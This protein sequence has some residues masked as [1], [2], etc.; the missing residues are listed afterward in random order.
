VYKKI[1][2]RELVVDGQTLLQALERRRF[3]V[4]G[5]FWIQ[6]EGESDDWTLVIASPVVDLVGP[7]VAYQRIQK[8]LAE[9]P[10]LTQLELS[11]IRAVG[12]I[13]SEYPSLRE[14]AMTSS[15]MGHGPATGVPR[16]LVFE[17]SYIYK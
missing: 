14:L 11:D 17:H 12:V 1:L 15:V 10:N 9:L 6:I 7:L 5:A 8:V 16:N 13:G 4:E 3:R 2:V